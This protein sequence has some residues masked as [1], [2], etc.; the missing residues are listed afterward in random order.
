[1]ARPRWGVSLVGGGSCPQ[2]PQIDP[3]S[4]LSGLDVYA[5]VLDSFF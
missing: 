5:H 2:S 3:L 4:R 1:M